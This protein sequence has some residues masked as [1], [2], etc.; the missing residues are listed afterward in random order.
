MRAFA[1]ALT[2]CSG[3]AWL[4]VLLLVFFF[5]GSLAFQKSGEPSRIQTESEMQHF[6]IDSPEINLNCLKVHSLDEGTLLV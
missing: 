2:S 3:R 5:P 6:N 4:F 1:E